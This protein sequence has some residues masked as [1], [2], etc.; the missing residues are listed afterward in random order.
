MPRSADSTVYTLRFRRLLGPHE[1]NDSPVRPLRT[2]LPHAS[3]AKRFSSS[4][5]S[6][7][8]KRN[9]RNHA[10]LS[11]RH[12]SS[13]I[14]GFLVGIRCDPGNKMTQPIQPEKAFFKDGGSIPNNKLPLLLYRLVFSPETRDLA[15]VIEERFTGNCWT[16]SWRASVFPFHHFHST[17]HEALAVYRG[18]ARMCAFL[19]PRERLRWFSAPRSV[20]NP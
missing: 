20:R 2:G 5:P 19:L 10:F 4:M 3:S 14:G 12:A 7:L 17:T 15:S 13:P 11:R 6:A 9:K 16:A 8:R 18:S 1:T